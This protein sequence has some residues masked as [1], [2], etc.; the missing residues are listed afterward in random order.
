METVALESA[1]QLEKS[2]AREW[3][4]ILSGKFQGASILWNE[5]NAEC[6]KFLKGNGK[7]ELT[8][9][10]RGNSHWDTSLVAFFYRLQQLADEH[11]Q[12]IKMQRA[13]RGLQALLEVA[14]KSK[15][16]LRTSPEKTSWKSR[17]WVR[18]QEI[19]QQTKGG[20]GFI[21]QVVQSISRALQGKAYSR[22]E[23]YIVLLKQVGIDALPI[24]SL[25]SF[26]VGVILGFIGVVQLARFGAA[27]YVADL[28]GIAMAREMGAIMTGVIMAGRTGAAFAATIGTM[29]VN[30]ELD[31]LETFGISPIDFLVFPRILAMA[32]MMPLLTVFSIF[33]GIAGGMMIALPLFDFT[34]LQYINETVNSVSLIN[35]CLGVFKGFVFG[36]LIAGLGCLRGLQCQRSASEVGRVTTSAVVSGI[37]AII[38]ADALFAFLFN[39]LHI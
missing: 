27:I 24:V 7:R 19:I 2:S 34:L 18:L 36:L 37:T 17:F 11:H 38:I 25:I 5:L 16:P 28:V 15:K 14:Q 13:P 31:A 9:V 3:K 22:K 1:Y 4:L 32:I 10:F 35:F 29:K 26:L 33:I 6:E 12:D 8:I 20:I 21:G 23:D 39:A 30:E